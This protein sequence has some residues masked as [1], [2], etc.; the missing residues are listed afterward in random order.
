M[1]DN[2]PIQQQ[3]YAQ[4]LGITPQQQQKLMAAQQQEALAQTLLQQGTTPID[5]SNRQIGGVG[6]RIS[7]FEGLAKLAD[8]VSGK[9]Q[10][11][12]ANDALANALTPQGGQAQQGMAGLPPMAGLNMDAATKAMFD[13]YY[14]DHRPGALYRGTDA[15]MHT[16][17]TD[18][19]LNTGTGQASP[20]S[21]IPNGN[22]APIAPVQTG[23]LPPPQGDLPPQY[24]NAPSP[25]AVGNAAVSQGAPQLPTSALGAPVGGPIPPPPSGMPNVNTSG[26]TA[27][28]AM[29]AIETAKANAVAQGAVAPAAAKT[30]AEDT[31]KNLVEAQKT[32]NVAA[33]NLPRAM[34]RFTELRGAAKD[35]SYGGGVSEQEPEGG[36]LD[37]FVPGPD[38]ARTFAQSSI[39][40]AL[41]PKTALANQTMEQATKQGILTELGPQMQGLKGN[42]YLESIASGASG[43]NLADPPAAKVQAINGLQDQ[44]ISNL[45]SL[46]QQR[47]DMGDPSA[48]SDLSLAQLIT[49]HA[50]PAQKVSVIDP[51]GNL[52]RVDAQHLPDLIQAGGQI[53]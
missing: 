16:A 45:K 26:M 1:A 32:F 44:Y 27:A 48:P 50:D 36:F 24:A 5:T 14:A 43:L 23:N 31:A 40:S 53:R 39:G 7:P 29:A 49:Q 15:Q 33:S 35:A 19:Q 41:E 8:V 46:A 20:Q 30:Q 2:S 47:R 4:A 34:Q 9:Y 28:Q 38:Y 6:Y 22:P 25:S 52:G 18:Q 3:F 21:Q 10:Q 13:N 11:S 42:K 37:H 17:P 12:T 51:K